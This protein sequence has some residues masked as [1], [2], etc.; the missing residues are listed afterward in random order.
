MSHLFPQG[1][2]VNASERE[3][4]RA[5]EIYRRLREHFP[6]ARLT[7][8]FEH[9]YQLLVATILAARFRDDRVNQITPRFFKRFPDVSSL[10]RASEE[11]ILEG[12]RG[13][14][15]AQV[16]A[17]RL[18]QVA[19]ILVERFGGEIPRSVEV[20]ASLPGIGRKT[21]NVVLGNALGVVE[22]IEVD[23]HIA[24]VSQRLGLS[25]HKT[26]EKIEED[27]MKKLPRDVWVSFSHVAKELGR[28]YC[29]PRN[30]RCSECP[31]EELCPRHG[32]S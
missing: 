7:L 30:P 6:D 2:E 16:K 25:R 10:A 31:V 27:L 13:V 20:L 15:M 29:R 18:K 26:P 19:Q 21:A 5:R 3:K 22:G 8:H 1:E 14:N 23:S 11:E 32:V 9:A 12:I 28:K 4:A 17:Q 24:R